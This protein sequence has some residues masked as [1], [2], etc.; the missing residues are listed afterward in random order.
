MQF[1][2][3]TLKQIKKNIKKEQFIEKQISR[4]LFFVFLWFF[5]LIFGAFNSNTVVTE[6]L[7]WSVISLN[8]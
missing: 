8:D 1:K 7:A 4:A 2:T 3:E 5:L 6:S